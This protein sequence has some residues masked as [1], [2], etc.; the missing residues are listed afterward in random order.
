M[1]DPAPSD[2]QKDPAAC[3]LPVGGTKQIIHTCHLGPVQLSLKLVPINTITVLYTH[4]N[5]VDM[6][7]VFDLVPT[8]F[9]SIQEAQL[10]NKVTDLLT[11]PMLHIDHSF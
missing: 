3:V 10:T 2:V 4:T 6:Q 9:L 8:L 5:L 7:K 11:V 1:G